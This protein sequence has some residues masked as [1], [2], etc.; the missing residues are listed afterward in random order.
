[1][2]RDWRNES[3]VKSTRCSSRGPGFNSQHTQVNSKLPVTLVFLWASG[4]HVSGTQIHAGK[5]NTH[6]YETKQKLTG[7]FIY[8]DPKIN[9]YR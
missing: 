6:M 1:M 4:I 7:L 2:F 3:V 8:F 5:T 9:S